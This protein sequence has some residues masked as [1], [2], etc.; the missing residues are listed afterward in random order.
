MKKYRSE[1]DP[2]KAISK[3]SWRYHHLGIPTSIPHPDEK[4][5]EKY[6]MYISGFETSDF[7]IEWMRFFCFDFYIFLVFLIKVGF[8]RGI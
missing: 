2:P 8:V 4:Y 7:G 5:L 6:K 3:Y 1:K